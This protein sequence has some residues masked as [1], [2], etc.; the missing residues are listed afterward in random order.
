M[1]NISSQPIVLTSQN[2]F[3]DVSENKLLLDSSFEINTVFN[4][5]SFVSITWGT[6]END[7]LNSSPF[8]TKNFQELNLVENSS[9]QTLDTIILEPTVDF[10][11]RLSSIYFESAGYG[12]Q[13]GVSSLYFK[14]S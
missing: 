3:N 11:E 6:T 1:P 2:T 4:P 10:D 5:S 9:N 7:V 13:S 12:I 8:S 14:Y